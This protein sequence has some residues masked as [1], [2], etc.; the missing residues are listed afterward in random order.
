M[1][2][3]VGSAGEL[4]CTIRPS[5]RGFWFEPGGGAGGAGAPGPGG[6]GGGPASRGPRPGPPGPHPGPAGGAA[7]ITIVC[8]FAVI[9]CTSTKVLPEAVALAKPETEIVTP[10]FNTETSLAPKGGVRAMT[11]FWKTNP[12]TSPCGP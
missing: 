12:L 5:I 8:P 6:G 9:D 3:R 4:D 7:F 10:G 2:L 1:R 11:P